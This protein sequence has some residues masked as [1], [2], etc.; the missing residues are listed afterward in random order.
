MPVLSS[1]D[2]SDLA[3]VLSAKKAK[4]YELKKAY[5][6][7]IK[8]TIEGED[9][10]KTDKTTVIVGKMDGTWVLLDEGDL[11]ISTGF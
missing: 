5:K 7:K 4:K 6:V 2:M 8:Y 9:A 1:N 10:D 11:P 3:S